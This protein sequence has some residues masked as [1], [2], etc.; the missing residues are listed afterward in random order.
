[1]KVTRPGIS[2]RRNCSDISKLTIDLRWGR[3]Y[4]AEPWRTTAFLHFQ[5]GG[6]SPTLRR[7]YGRKTLSLLF[8]PLECQRGAGPLWSNHSPAAI[9]RLETRSAQEVGV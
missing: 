9:I 7:T 8:W 1:M 6:R 2:S 5:S 3:A 4:H